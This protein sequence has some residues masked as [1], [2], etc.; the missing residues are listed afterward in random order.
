MSLQRLQKQLQREIKRNPQKAG[1]LGLLVLVAGWFWAPLIFAKD[2]PVPVVPAP[3]AAATNPSPSA[4]VAST[5][6][7]STTA[8]SNPTN[9]TSTTEKNGSW[10]AWSRAIEH[11][12]RMKTVG[13]VTGGTEYRNPFAPIRKVEPKPEVV[14]TV[15][16]EVPVVIEPPISPEEVGL[17]VTGTILSRERRTAMINGQPY[18]LGDELE[19]RAGVIF[20]IAGI[21]PNGVLLERK[22]QQFALAIRRSPRAGR[23]DLRANN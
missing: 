19:P 22:G 11:D 23:I 20:K 16:V 14:E 10:Q 1:A 5:S 3:V 18:A 6:T 8:V 17:E 9:N 4:P 2:E 7:A 15:E 12:P 13:V 21:G